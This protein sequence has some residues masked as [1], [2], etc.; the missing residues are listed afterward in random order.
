MDRRRPHGAHLLDELRADLR[1]ARPIA[2]MVEIS[3]RAGSM[4][5]VVNSFFTYS[6]LLAANALPSR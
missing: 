5:S 6:I 4:S 3:S 1:P 2:R